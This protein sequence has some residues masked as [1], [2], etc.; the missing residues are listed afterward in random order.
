MPILY[1]RNKIAVQNGSQ[2]SVVWR[3]QRVK[4][5]RGVKTAR[6]AGPFYARSKHQGRTAWTK[7]QGDTLNAAKV[8]AGD[9]IS[10]QAVAA[11]VAPA[12]NIQNVTR[13]TIRAAID[14]YLDQKAG[15]APKTKAQY[16]TTLEQFLEAVQGRVRFLDEI[17][18]DVMRV[19]KKFLEKHQYSGKTID[20]RINIVNFLLKKN[21]VTARLPKD[22]MPV[23]QVEA[24]VPYPD[25]DLEKLFAAMDE[26]ETLRYRFFLGSGCRDQEV[27]FASWPDINFSRSEYTVR[28]KP[29]DGFAPKSHESRT[30]KLPTSLMIL[31]KAAYKKKTDDRWIFA[32]KD[33]NPENHSLRKL[34]RIAL[35]AKL[36]CG[37]CRA[38]MNIGR[39]KP[40]VVEV[41]C[42]THPICQHFY[43]HRFRKTCATRWIE[44][45]ISIKKVQVWFG[46]KSLETTERY[47]GAISSDKDQGMV[48]SAAGD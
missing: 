43:L 29:A 31:L 2:T 35:N 9:R 4:E 7:L 6:L 19:Y 34:K 46:H 27:T 30:I 21:G 1:T 45:G 44:A 38:T 14:R 25:E 18:P 23:V 24:A 12:I 15:K 42:A 17:T 10:Q 36:N 22:E 5:G 48:D 39:Y 13:T 32:N 26:L 8:E 20:T 28:G 40:K 47:L 33:G 41:S 37:H 3:Y 11:P 16:R